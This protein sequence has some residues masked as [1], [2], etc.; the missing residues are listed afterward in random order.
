MPTDQASLDAIRPTTT[1]TSKLPRS[2]FGGYDVD[3]SETGVDIHNGQVVGLS[4]FVVGSDKRVHLR[5]VPLPSPIKTSQGK[6]ASIG[7]AR[8]I[9]PTLFAP[10]DLVEW[11]VQHVTPG[12]LITW[13]TGEFG[14]PAGGEIDMEYRPDWCATPQTLNLV[15]HY[16]G[17]SNAGLGGVTPVGV[18]L[19]KPHVRSLEW[20]ADGK[21]MIARINGVEVQRWPMLWNGQPQII[22]TQATAYLPYKAGMAMPELSL[23]SWVHYKPKAA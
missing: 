18:D 23:G 1:A 15:Q 12:W 21:T 16:P 11:D 3:A 10:G 14:W 5:C 22:V 8:L 13:T 6:M 19:T 17:A 7:Q 9:A 2:T 20:S 4:P